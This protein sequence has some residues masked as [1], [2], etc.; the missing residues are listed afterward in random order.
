MRPRTP[1]GTEPGVPRKGRL[2]ATTFVEMVVTIFLLVAFAGLVLPLFWGSS[3]ANAAAVVE[4]AAQ[5]S[6]LTLASVLPRLCSEVRPPYWARQERVFQASGNEWKARFVNGREEGCL[7]VKREGDSRLSLATEDRTLS[8]GNLPGL[9]VD[10]WE[11]DERIIG[12][13]VQWRRGA[14]LREFHAAWGAFAL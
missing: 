13:T 4:N 12:I 6:E 10:W 2:A 14:E 8:I 7:V 9:A 11:K 3:R 5:R 1:S